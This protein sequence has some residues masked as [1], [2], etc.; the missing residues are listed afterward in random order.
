MV[1][2][3]ATIVSAQRPHMETRMDARADIKADR[4]ELRMDRKEM[5]NDW[6]ERGTSTREELKMRHDE[7]KDSIKN[8]RM[9]IKD[10]IASSTKEIKERFDVKKKE[11]IKERLANMEGKFS[12]AIVRLENFDMKVGAAIERFDE[13]GKDT[14]NAKTA[15]VN[16]KEELVN[17]KDIL[18]EFQVKAGAIVD[19]DE[20]SRVALKAEAEIVVESIKATHKAYVDVVVLLRA[21]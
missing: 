8:R 9:E 7:I 17:A 1:A 6:R 16:A 3:S 11:K 14:T 19:G 20:V 5:R 10:R 18:A 15:L 4:V 13:K 2:V 21:N 12:A